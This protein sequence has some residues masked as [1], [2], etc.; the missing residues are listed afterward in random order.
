MQ[1]IFFLFLFVVSLVNAQLLTLRECLD[2]SLKNYP[3][4]KTFELKLKESKL[5]Y[6]SAFSDYLPQ[7]NL[8]GQYSFTQTYTLPSNGVFHT[9]DDNGWNIG[10]NLKQKLWDF[11]KTSSKVDA[12]KIQKEI[13]Q[14]SLENFKALLAYRVKLFYAAMVV[15]KEAIKVREKDLETKEAYYNQANALVNQGLKTRADASRFLSALSIAKENLSRAKT[16]Y[17]KAKNTL[18]LYMNRDISQD[19]ELEQEFVKQEF[20]PSSEK[21]KE[22]LLH[23][24]TLQ[25]E[26]KNVEKNLLLHKSAKAAGYGSLDF[27]ASY[28]HI[29]TLNSYNSKLAAITLNVPLYSGGRVSAEAQKAKIAADIAQKQK[30]SREIALKEEIEN[31][32]Y[33]I[34]QYDKTI[35]AKKAQ[36][37]AAEDTK[38]VLDARYKEGLATY[39]EVLDATSLLLG[40]KLGLLEAYYSRVAAIYRIDYLKGKYDE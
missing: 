32:F 10:V 17:N 13:S 9:V 7:I 15:N 14:L 30:Y 21:E 5:S 26:T 24:K 16:N 36:I 23:N 37:L 1:K 40:A 20:T 29:D 6:K 11:S 22:I 28:T 4:V 2:E 35:A 34:R 25:I 38:N 12:Q 8:N 33:D 31:L 18:S 39:I 3:D 19:V 27:I